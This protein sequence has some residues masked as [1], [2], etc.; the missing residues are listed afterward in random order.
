MNNEIKKVI[1]P[2]GGMGTRFLPLSKVIPKE[3]FPLVDKPMVQYIIEEA[4][5]SGITEIVFV[6]NPNQK[7]IINYVKPAKELEKILLKK[8]KEELLKELKEFESILESLNIQFVNQNKPLGDGHAIL[9]A[10]KLI[11]DESFGV[12]F[13]DDIVDSAVPVLSQLIDIYK[14]CNAPVLALKR[15]PKENISAYGVVEMEKIAN[16]L[17]KIKKI[18]EKPEKE[19]A[20]S[21][22][23]IIGKYVLTPEVFVYLK[24]ASP[25]S[26]G[27]II[28]AEVLEKMLNEGKII[29]GYEVKGEW[30]E[31]GDKEKWLKSFLYFARKN[32]KI[33][34]EF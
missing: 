22:L 4:K 20:P 32:P 27:E 10:A 26:R 28:L 29:Y 9:Q 15:V 34:K 12:L 23:A 30:L 21:D 31:C 5:K 3:F 11:G 6:I 1:I 17:Y 33:N 16:R 14:T 8:K 18:V 13:V 7:M 24:K 25:S 19:N 2:I